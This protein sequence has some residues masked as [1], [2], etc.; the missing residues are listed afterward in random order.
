MIQN[1]WKNFVAHMNH[2]TDLKCAGVICF[3][4]DAKACEL[5]VEKIRSGEMRCRIYP[6]EGYRKAM[7][8]EARE[9]EMCIVVDWNGTP[10]AVIETTHVRS[11][12]I[13]E[14]SDEIC[15]QEGICA[16]LDSWREKQ[17]PFIKTEVEELGFEFD[18]STV[19]TVETFKTVYLED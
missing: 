6:A 2:E 17:M 8:G 12:M 1:Y 18:N 15:Q 11:M 19:V 14:L 7:S 5:A 9:G 16:D 4:M 3:G 13:S 10:R